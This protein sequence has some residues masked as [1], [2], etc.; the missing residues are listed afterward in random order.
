[1]NSVPPDDPGEIGSRYLPASR[2]NLFP[3]WPASANLGD[4]N[5]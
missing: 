3:N 2:V 5:A 4:N 1:M